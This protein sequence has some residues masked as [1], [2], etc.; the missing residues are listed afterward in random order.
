MIVYWMKKY[1]KESV[2]ISLLTMKRLTLVSKERM[3]V[4]I[5]NHGA[6]VG[7]VDGDPLAIT[8]PGTVDD[9]FES[10]VVNL[11]MGQRQQEEVRTFQF[12]KL[13]EHELSLWESR[14]P[15][16]LSS[17][18]VPPEAFVEGFWKINPMEFLRIS[19]SRLTM[20]KVSD[21]QSGW[22]EK[23]A[24]WNSATIDF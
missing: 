3:M 11:K 22:S 14:E 21:V 18:Q 23:N 17:L 19:C 12:P 4:I 24:R 5:R 7:A 2:M 8:G 15:E 13:T 20:I 1:T 16:F 10:F 6:A 9:D